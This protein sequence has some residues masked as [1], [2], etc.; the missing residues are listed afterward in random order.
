MNLSRRGKKFTPCWRAHDYRAGLARSGASSNAESDGELTF[1]R[2]MPRPILYACPFSL[3]YCV[4]KAGKEIEHGCGD[5]DTLVIGGICG[6][7]PKGTGEVSDEDGNNLLPLHF[8][9][10]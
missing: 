5:E 4:K 9:S 2:S 6:C 3:K 8:G 1:K 7:R 10:R